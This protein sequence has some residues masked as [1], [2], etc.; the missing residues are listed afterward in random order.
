MKRSLLLALV[1][2]LSLTLAGCGKS[3]NDVSYERDGGYDDV[4]ETRVFD[5]PGGY[6][7][8][9]NSRTNGI[10]H[11][12]VPA[13]EPIPTRKYASKIDKAAKKAGKS[14]VAARQMIG[15]LD[16]DQ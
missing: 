9:R 7:A 16:M 5:S 6:T 1:A 14:Q 11:E 12:A 4:G 10:S 8:S 13:P 15:E 2:M 3:R